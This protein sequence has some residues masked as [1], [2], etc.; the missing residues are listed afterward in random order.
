MACI[1]LSSPRELAEILGISV[2]FVENIRLISSLALSSHFLDSTK[3]KT[4]YEELE[5]QIR[6][7]LPYVRRLPPCVHKYS[8]IPELVEE[9]VRYTLISIR[10]AFLY[11]TIITAVSVEFLRRT[12]WWTMPQTLQAC[13]VSFGTPNVTWRQFNGY[14]EAFADVVRSKNVRRCNSITRN[15]EKRPER[16]WVLW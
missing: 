3:M 11:F 13:S 7:E 4:L 5:R 9:L 12:S 8:H 2:S 1:V 14:V 10:T 15:T 6:D 16:C